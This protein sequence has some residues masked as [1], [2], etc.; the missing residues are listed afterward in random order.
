VAGRDA[1]HDKGNPPDQALC[2]ER[3]LPIHRSNV[4]LAAFGS[5]RFNTPQSWS[6]GLDRNGF[7]AQGLQRCRC[8]FVLPALTTTLRPRQ[9]RKGLRKGRISP[10]ARVMVIWMA[11]CPIGWIPNAPIRPENDIGL[12]WTLVPVSL[13]TALMNRPRTPAAVELHKGKGKVPRP[14]MPTFSVS[15]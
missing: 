10:R 3:M 7:P 14:T 2:P 11:M 12:K 5:S 13:A 6:R 1:V 9:R 8:C 15:A 4:D